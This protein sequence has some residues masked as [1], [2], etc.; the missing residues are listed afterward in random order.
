MIETHKKVSGQRPQENETVYSRA[1]AVDTH[2]LKRLDK[3]LQPYEERLRHQEAFRNRLGVKVVDKPTYQ[4]YITGPIKRFEKE[5]MAFL[6]MRPDNPIGKA[7]R[8]KFKARTGHD[9]Y[10]TPLP[11]EALDPEDRFGRAMADAGYRAC[12]EYDPNPFPITP[13]VSSIPSM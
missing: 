4:R 6:C 5:R 9:H 10:L 11:Y 8:K 13:P 7:L 3:A 2:D 1:A 12:C